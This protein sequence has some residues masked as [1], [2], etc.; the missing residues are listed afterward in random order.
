M[1]GEVI[2]GQLTS[3][4][5]ME[6]PDSG[7]LSSSAAANRGPVAVNDDRAGDRRGAVVTIDCIVHYPELIDA[8]SS[9]VDHICACPVAV[10]IID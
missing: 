2:E 3:L 8:S 6:K 9:Q 7:F 5:N 1:Q 4:G 10:G